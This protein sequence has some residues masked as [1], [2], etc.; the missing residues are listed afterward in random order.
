MQI[1][2]VIRGEDHIP[3]TP[4][5]LLLQTTLDFKH[6]HYAHLPLI[7]DPDR[8][9]MSKRFTATAVAEYQ[10][11]GYL[12][13]A[14]IN[15]MAL[16]GWHPADDHEIL[17]REELIE[18]FDLS[19]VQK[20]GA[21]FNVEKLNWLNGQYLKKISAGDILK[22]LDWKNTEQNKKIIAL[23]KERAKTLNDFKELA[24]FVFKLPAYEVDLL[25]WKNTSRGETV[26][27][28]EMVVELIKADKPGEIPIIAEKYGRGE[29]YWPLRA[30]LSGLKESPG[31]MELLDVLGKKEALSR[32][33]IAIEKLRDG[34]LGL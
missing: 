34:G 21:V 18:K 27:S 25:C 15:F 13:E 6:P 1:S 22:R 8:S 28:L 5:Q 17:T 16:L 31:P 30:A 29:I 3:N 24:G 4:R 12:P 11:Q 10:K 23:F 2:H 32:I 33:K 7:L 14:L 19:R 9:K 26:K 20:A